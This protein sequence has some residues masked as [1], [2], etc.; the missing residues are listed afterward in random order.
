MNISIYTLAKDAVRLDFH[1][2][3][4]LTHHL[5]YADEIVICEGYSSDKT[6]EVIR[7]LNH[8][9]LKVY[10]RR[11]DARESFLELLAETRSRCSGD[12]CIKLD[13]DE[14][15]PEWEWDRLR[16]YL[17]VTDA[18]IVPVRMVNF[19]GNY[20]V[21]HN[22]PEKSLWPVVKWPIHRNTDDFELWGDTSNVRLK[23]KAVDYG[24]ADCEGVEVHHFGAVRDAARLREKWRTQAI[25]DQRCSGK[26]KDHSRIIGLPSLL[27]DFFR[28]RWNDPAYMDYLKIYPGPYMDIVTQHPEEFIRDK[29]QL[30]K[31]LK[32]SKG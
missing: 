20:K 18:D 1:L 7:S 6:Y 3:S 22:E 24:R 2:K 23:G 9:K 14:F 25:R 21:F 31:T 16:A 19:Y 28:H 4:M 26:Y 17:A 5:Q 29:M 30:Y 13:I 15:I 27:F 10:R 11:W 8:P 12:W 32:R